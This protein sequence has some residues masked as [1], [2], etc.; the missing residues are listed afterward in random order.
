MEG[1]GVERS[2]HY[3]QLV[4]SEAQ[5]PYKSTDYWVRSVDA[6]TR[7]RISPSMLYERI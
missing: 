7:Y 5:S 2:R 1:S 6:K 3:S 4:Y